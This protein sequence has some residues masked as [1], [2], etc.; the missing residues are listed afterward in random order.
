MSFNIVF[1]I[2]T[3]IL[4]ILAV[5]LKGER[6]EKLFYLF[7]VDLLMIILINRGVGMALLFIGIIFPLCTRKSLTS[8]SSLSTEV[9]LKEFKYKRISYICFAPLLILSIFS[10]RL[11]SLEIGSQ[12]PIMVILGEVSLV[13]ITF[14]LLIPKRVNLK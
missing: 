7:I 13:I 4:V 10:Y 6:L 11:P 5:N 1:S 8:A 3:L 9:K 14:L 12:S 2:I